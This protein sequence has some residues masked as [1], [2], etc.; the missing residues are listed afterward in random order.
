MLVRSEP[1]V[2][3]AYVVRFQKAIRRNGP[4]AG[5]VRASVRKQ[6]CKTVVY[7]QFSVAN[8]A[9]AV[10]AQSVKENYRVTISAPGPDQPRP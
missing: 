6:N 10:V 9:D 1:P 2:P 3:A 4:S 8:H 5:A 7:E